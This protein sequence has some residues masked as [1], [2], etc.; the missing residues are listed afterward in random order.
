MITSLARVPGTRSLSHFSISIDGPRCLASKSPRA[1]CMIMR[2][3]RTDSRFCTCDNADQVPN[4]SVREDLACESR[5]EPL[6]LCILTFCWRIAQIRSPDLAHSKTLGSATL[7]C[8]PCRFPSQL[9]LS[10]QATRNLQQRRCPRAAIT[11][12]AFWRCPSTGTNRPALRSAIPIDFSVYDRPRVAS[13]LRYEASSNAMTYKAN[14]P[15]DCGQV[16]TAN[17][18]SATCNRMAIFQARCELELGIQ[19]LDMAIDFALGAPT[20]ASRCSHRPLVQMRCASNLSA[21][22]QR[23]TAPSGCPTTSGA[24]DCDIRAA[25]SDIRRPVSTWLRP[26]R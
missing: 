14:E 26:R 23:T 16:T 19:H 24:G 15:E 7:G 9:V 5:S 12:P 18:Q 8:Q 1:D 3:D 22:Y 13:R 21:P 10:L 4:R 11:L 20:A 6:G 25:I 17:P 2:S